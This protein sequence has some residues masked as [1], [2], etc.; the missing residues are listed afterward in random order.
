MR[1]EPC[2][3]QGSSRHCEQSTVWFG[4]SDSRRRLLGLDAPEQTLVGAVPGFVDN[5]EQEILRDPVKRKLL[6]QICGVGPL[7]GHDTSNCNQP[8]RC[9]PRGQM[10]PRALL[11]TWL[12]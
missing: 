6:D 2:P 5:F 4:L 3:L 7:P 11:Q 10:L 8:Q 12:I 1:H 9:P